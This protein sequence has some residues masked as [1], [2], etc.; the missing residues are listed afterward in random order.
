[1]SPS[2]L[3][4]VSEQG[5]L[6]SQIESELLQYKSE[7]NQGL[8][9]LATGKTATTLSTER[10]MQLII[11]L[12]ERKVREAIEKNKSFCGCLMCEHHSS[13]YALKEKNN[14]KL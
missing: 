7:L 14:G 13:A 2:T 11:T 4:D 8:N 9:Q 5:E 12:A 6:R 3:P 1:M 10:I